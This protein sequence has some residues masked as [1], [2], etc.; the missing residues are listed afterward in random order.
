M[1]KLAETV[2]RIQ[3]MTWS[4]DRE[5]RTNP[6]NAEGIEMMYRMRGKAVLTALELGAQPDYLAAITRA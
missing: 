4:I 5:E 3:D 1:N 6:G 2:E